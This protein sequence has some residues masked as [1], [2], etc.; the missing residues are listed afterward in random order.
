M[1]SIFT[2][3]LLRQIPGNIL[4]QD[5]LFF[6]IRDIHPQDA[7]H[8]LIIPKEEIA[9]INDVSD[10]WEAL[11]WKMMKLSKKMAH[12]FGFSQWYKIMMNFGEYQEVPHIHLHVISKHTQ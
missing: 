2:K 12:N 8:L 1:A 10:E 3:I 4:Y 9:S 6:V 11:L 5:E 7:V